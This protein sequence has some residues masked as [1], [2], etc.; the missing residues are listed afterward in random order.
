M[1]IINRIDGFRWVVHRTDV[2]RATVDLQNDPK[3]LDGVIDCN[4][5]LIVNAR[6]DP[7]LDVYSESTSLTFTTIS[8]ENGVTRD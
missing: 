2:A 6:V 7:V 5:R 4:S 8:S 3:K 1:K